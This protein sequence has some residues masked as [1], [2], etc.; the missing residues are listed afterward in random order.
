MPEHLKDVKDLKDPKGLSLMSLTSLMSLV[1][2][3]AFLLLAA[4]A[5]AQCSLSTTGVSFGLYD[6]LSPTPLAS[7]GSI[8]WSC[9]PN[10]IIELHLGTGGSGTFVP[11]RMASGAEHLSYNLFLD[12]AGTQIWGDGTGGTS[13]FS[14]DTGQGGGRSRTVTIYGRIPAQQDVAAGVYA[15]TVVATLWL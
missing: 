9:P 10:R 11:R 1:S 2:F 14:I 4:P 15:D 6:A 12:A 3:L 5:A 8:T 7:T 13:I